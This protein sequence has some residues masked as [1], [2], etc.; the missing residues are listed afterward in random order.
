MQDFKMSESTGYTYKDDIKVDTTQ[1]SNHPAGT[2]RITS[3]SAAS[4][5]AFRGYTKYNTATRQHRVYPLDPEEA[6]RNF[7]DTIGRSLGWHEV[8][9]NHTL[10][11]VSFPAAGGGAKLEE[12]DV[13]EVSASW[14]C[15]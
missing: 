14:V 1:T 4:E 10:D 6:A 3:G 15:L 11:H 8:G 12:N 13:F 5:F 7:S 2:V 9:E